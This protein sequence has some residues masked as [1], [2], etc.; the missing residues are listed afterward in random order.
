[1]KIFLIGH[2]YKYAV[3]QMLLTLFPNDQY[4]YS[5]E[6]DLTQSDDAVKRLDD[7]DTGSFE[8][9]LILNGKHYA[10]AITII[11]REGLE[12]RGTA[13][14]SHAALNDKLTTDRLLQRIIKISFYRAALHFIKTPP[15]WGAL[16]GIRPAKLA[17]AELEAGKSHKATASALTKTYY[18]S[19]DRAKL[20]TD[21][22]LVSLDVNKTLDVRD[23]ALYVGIPFCPTRC[24]YCSF[25]SNSVERSFDLI[26][27]FTA[28]LLEEIE[29]AA[30]LLRSLNLR[31]VSIY[32]GGGTPTALPADSLERI[33]SAIG[34]LFDLRHIREY[35]VEAGRPD[36][37]TREKLD[38]IARHG[39]DRVCVNPQS[40]NPVV[41]EAIG[42]AHTPEEITRSVREARSAAM[43]V[44]MDIIA[45]LPKDTPQGF[46][47]T[48]TQVLAMRPENITIHTLS[49]KKGSKLMLS[50]T[51]IP[52]G[53]EVAEMLENA[54]PRLRDSGYRPY[55]LYRQK[56]ISGGFENVGWSL[57][58]AEG[59][60]NIIMMEELRTVIAVGGGG[61]TKLVLPTGRIERIFNAKFPRE[62]VLQSEKTSDKMVRIREL[63]RI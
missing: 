15:V 57:P 10:Q 42:R 35:T 53:A 31:V 52:G 41:L 56:F 22:A 4:E 18:V 20:C 30:E 11:R 63:L 51:D 12:G 32:I 62:Y 61:V 6:T 60:Y 16:T 28:Q 48:L 1:M 25:V 44:N 14:I 5:T 29:A 40:M 45:G 47:D 49:L 38:I 19:P 46:A 36:T 43:S 24:D 39:A 9:C 3:E 59:L 21:A 27:P 26:E 33:M 34:R 55:Y 37:I 8:S 50:G 54:S 13:R 23:I 58:G 7:C 2:D 17:A